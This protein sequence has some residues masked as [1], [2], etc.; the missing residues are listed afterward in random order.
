[1]KAMLYAWV[2]ALVLT[3]ATKAFALAVASCAGELR[4]N[5]LSLLKVVP[6]VLLL[7]NCF[8]DPGVPKRLSGG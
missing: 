5:Y 4:P 7:G 8:S 2:C 1:M 6:K 3:T